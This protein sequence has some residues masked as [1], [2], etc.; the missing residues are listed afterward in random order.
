M[1]SR[2]RCARAVTLA[3]ALGAAPSLHAQ[4]AYRDQV[5]HSI[6][7]CW[8]VDAHRTITLDVG[9]DRAITGIVLDGFADAPIRSTVTWLA[10]DRRLVVNAPGGFVGFTVSLHGAAAP[11]FETWERDHSRYMSRAWRDAHHA[12]HPLRIATTTTLVRCASSSAP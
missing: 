2:T 8:R 4:T 9:S 7:G 12:V 3:F 5:T 11:T 10:A 6:A 1:H